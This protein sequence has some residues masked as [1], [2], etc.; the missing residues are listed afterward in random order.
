MNIVHKQIA[1]TYKK[2]VHT[3]KKLL[4]SETCRETLINGL[5]GNLNCNKYIH[6][7]ITTMEVIGKYERFFFLLAP[8]KGKKST[9]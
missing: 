5:E 1:T 8:V 9:A 6:F 3:K 7:L 2:I 4:C